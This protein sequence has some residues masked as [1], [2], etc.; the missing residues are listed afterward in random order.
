MADTTVN[1]I[2]AGRVGQTLLRLLAQAPGYRVQDVLG[3]R[4]D[5]TQA[6]VKAA[7]AGHAV[8][9]MAEMRP[10]A[11]WI[12]SVADTEI[13]PVARDLADTLRDRARPHVPPVACHC[14]GFF[15]SDQLSALDDLGWHRASLHPVLSFAEPETA[16]RQFPGTYCGVEGDLDAVSA[17]QRMLDR[18]GAHPF[19]IR[20]DKKSLYH[21]AAVISNNF[22][23]VLQAIAR[24]AWAE[25]G[26]PQEIAEHLNEGLLRATYENVAASGPQTALTGPAARG[27][28]LVV[29]RQ[30]ADV[31]QWHPDAGSVYDTLSQMAHRLKSSG[32]PWGDQGD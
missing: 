26:V 2:G 24:E 12:L 8:A 29:E 22:T 11:L 20:S 15:A 6:A 25:A 19:P 18:L 7:G 5:A 4:S 23:V 28:T 9:C 21:A 31:A 17:V 13:A 1:I 14:S 10:A 3:R 30:G 16:T 27:D 32:S